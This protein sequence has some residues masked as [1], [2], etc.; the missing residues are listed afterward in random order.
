[1]LL[2]SK[3]KSSLQHQM[4]LAIVTNFS[5]NRL[6]ETRVFYIC[7]R[8]ISQVFEQITQVKKK[9]VDFLTFLNS[10][11]MINYWV[12]IFPGYLHTYCTFLSGEI[13]GIILVHPAGEIFKVWA[14]KVEKMSSLWNNLFLRSQIRWCNLILSYTVKIWSS[15]FYRNA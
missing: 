9:L 4:K 3:K 6:Y 15:L 10:L 5:S 2:V 7:R 8:S 11:V 14:Q 12:F 1:V 13:E